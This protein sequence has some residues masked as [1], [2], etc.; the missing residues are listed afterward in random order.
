M[1]VLNPKTEHN[2]KMNLNNKQTGTNTLI[3][4]L[5]TVPSYCK[6]LATKNCTVCTKIKVTLENY[7]KQTGGLPHAAENS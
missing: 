2:L 3:E 6:V 7:S 4:V 5:C 1:D